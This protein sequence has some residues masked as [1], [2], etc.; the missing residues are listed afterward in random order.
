[1]DKEIEVNSEPFEYTLSVI[2]GKWK[3]TIMFW[4]HACE[5]LRYGELKRCVKGIT[6]K[7]LSS[8]LKE[9]ESDDIIVRKEY[10]Q[11]PPKVEYFLSKKGLS[12]MPI[13]EEICKWG[14]LNIE[15]SDCVD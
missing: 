12:L 3:M 4:L 2:G 14:H 8:Q 13:L 10:H 1:M 9:L 15:D 5:V 7:M 6:H 11:V